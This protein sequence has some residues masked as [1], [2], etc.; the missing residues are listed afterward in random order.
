M[1][2]LQFVKTSKG[3]DI[4]LGGGGYLSAN[5]TPIATYP[6]GTIVE[7]V[8]PNFSPAKEYGGTWERFGQGKVL[9][10]FD[11]NDADFN[12]VK[13]LDENG[14]EVLDEN[15]DPIF[16][17]GG[18]KNHTLNLNEMPSHTHNL[19]SGTS[20]INGSE[21]AINVYMNTGYW[22]GNTN[23]MIHPTGGDQPHNNLQPYVVVYR[24]RR[25]A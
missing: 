25:V 21:Y 17:T 18:E 12:W 19:P 15:G 6:I 16:N 1:N 20:S 8:D 22:N 5:G 2:N 9:V 24:W 14:N 10:G 11:E 3:V 4:R 23:E 13:L 7:N